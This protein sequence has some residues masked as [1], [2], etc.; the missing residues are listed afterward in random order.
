MTPANAR[1]LRQMLEIQ[2]MLDKLNKDTRKLI[3][4][5]A[6]VLGGYNQLLKKTNEQREV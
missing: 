6:G 2:E 4:D 1:V 3:E 5:E